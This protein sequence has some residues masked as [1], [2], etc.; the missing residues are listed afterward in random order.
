MVL[1]K[2]E[3]KISIAQTTQT[4]SAVTAPRPAPAPLASMRQ[5]FRAR[6]VTFLKTLV[7]DYQILSPVSTFACTLGQQSSQHKTD[8]ASRPFAIRFLPY[9]ILS[10][11][12]VD[13]F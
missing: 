2:A 9:S 7:S 6:R 8:D 3:G 5:R 4:V 12:D 10:T 11:A 1:Y 13:L